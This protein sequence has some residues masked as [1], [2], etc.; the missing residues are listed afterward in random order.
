MSVRRL[1]LLVIDDDEDVRRAL[2]RFLR[3]HGYDVIA[4]ES[5]EAWLSAMT[6]VDG[7]VLDINLPGMTGLELDERMRRD[8]H[9]I[10]TVFITAHDESGA[11]GMNRVI[12][13][14]P[15]DTQRF[16]DA[17]QR[18]LDGR[19]GHHRRKPR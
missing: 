19:D 7:A 16:L 9:S 1:T 10:P 11:R 15:L 13:P 2:T 17:L 12:L 5:A 3:L 8:G 6:P 14:K 18:E 4:F